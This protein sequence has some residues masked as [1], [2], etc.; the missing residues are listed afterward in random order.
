MAHLNQCLL[1]NTG[2]AQQCRTRELNPSFLFN[3]YQCMVINEHKYVTKMAFSASMGG[4][5]RDFTTIFWMAEYLKSPIYNSNKVSKHI[6][7]QCGM[8]F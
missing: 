5:W 6:M 1:L 3:L 8:D 4:L 7:F 2:K